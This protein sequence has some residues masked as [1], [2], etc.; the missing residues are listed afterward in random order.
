MNRLF[1]LISAF[2]LFVFT[3]SCDEDLEETINN[4]VPELRFEVQGQSQTF[5][6]A[7]AIYSSTSD[8]T[9]LTAANTDGSL[10]VISFTFAG[11][12]RTE[13]FSIGLQDTS[14]NPAAGS[15]YGYYAIDGNVQSTDSNFV[16]SSGTLAITLEDDVVSGS[17]SAVGY[18]GNIAFGDS[19][20]VPMTDSVQVTGGSFA[21]VPV[22]NAN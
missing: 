6:V 8:Q 20:F 21:R 13:T 1:V 7:T 11:Q 16:F 5:Q 15:T 17:F 12:P 10:P 2:A 18:N 4:I 19:S 3:V 9:V 22:L 14:L